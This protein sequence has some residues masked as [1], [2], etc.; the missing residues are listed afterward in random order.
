QRVEAAVRLSDAA[1]STEADLIAL[2]TAKVGAFK[3]PDRV[4]LM[5]ELPKGPSGKIQRL[6]LA[7]ML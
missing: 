4:H 1:A 3:A 7:E 5:A 6:K 2:C